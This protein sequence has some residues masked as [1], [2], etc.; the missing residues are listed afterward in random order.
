MYLRKLQLKDAP[1]ML[2][3]MHDD[4]VVKALQ[5][6]F[7]EKTIEECNQFILSSEDQTHNLHLAIADDNDEYMGT[8]S[9][10]NI[11]NGTAEFAITI[12]KNAMGKGISKFG[13]AEII[14]MG[15]NDL[16]LDNIYWCVSPENIR[17]VRFYDKN[18]YNRIDASLLDIRGGYSQEQVQAYIWY[19]KKRDAKGGENI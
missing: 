19:Q 17:A 8:V 2:E 4:L 16:G 14:K 3:W 9:L 11:E 6:N 13:M 15:L 10:K 12:R 1:L 5:T 18:N 7:R